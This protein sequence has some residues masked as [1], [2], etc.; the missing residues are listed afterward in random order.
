MPKPLPKGYGIIRET[1]NV[2]DIIE[3]HKKIVRI[4]MK[5]QPLIQLA[6]GKKSMGS[7]KILE[8]I[9]SIVNHLLE[10]L[11]NKMNNIHSI[12]IKSTMGKPVRVSE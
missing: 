11:P 12:F 4:R 3:R 6:I 8:N 9:N 7:E 10:E 2:S 1:D 5:K